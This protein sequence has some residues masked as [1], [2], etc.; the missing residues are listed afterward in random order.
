MQISIFTKLYE[1]YKTDNWRK[2]IEFLLFYVFLNQTAF[3]LSFKESTK[4]QLRSH[5]K[6]ISLTKC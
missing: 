5:S 2:K 4:N 3:D 1:C 6:R